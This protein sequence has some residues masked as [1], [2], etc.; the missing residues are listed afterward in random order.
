LI[1]VVCVER[2]IHVSECW[3]MLHDSLWPKYGWQVLLYKTSG[4]YC[5][6]GAHRFIC[7]CGECHNQHI[8]CCVC[9][10]S[11]LFNNLSCNVKELCYKYFTP[12]CYM[13]SGMEEISLICFNFHFS[14][15]ARDELMQ[16]Q[17][18]LM[19]ELGEASTILHKATFRSL[20]LLDELGRGTST[21]D[22]TAIAI[23]AFHHL[24]TQVLMCHKFYCPTILKKFTLNVTF[25]PCITRNQL[26]THQLL[27]WQPFLII[28]PTYFCQ[29]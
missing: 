12:L 14:M 19:L 17:S 28:P 6:D 27:N 4:S 15:G 2:C 10:V 18:T 13:W 3:R 8:G 11:S 24:L 25:C 29:F 16:G 9:P 20:V 21:C 26:C 1:C 23:A 7:A 5:S 22:G